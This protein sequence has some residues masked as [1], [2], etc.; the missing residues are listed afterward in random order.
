MTRLNTIWHS[1]NISHR[2]KIKLYKSL[3][4]SILHV[5]SCECW[6]HKAE[7]ERRL[8]AFEFKSYRKILSINYTEHRTNEYVEQHITTKA[9]KQERLLTT[10]KKRTLK[11]F[12]YVN[13]HESLAKTIMQSSVQGKRARCD[14]GKNG[15][16]TSMTGREKILTNF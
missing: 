5:Y 15:Q 1:K 7:L 9:G 13:R 11:W 3:V 8:Q 6:T 2:T 14:P 16:I 4:T 12:G 10:I